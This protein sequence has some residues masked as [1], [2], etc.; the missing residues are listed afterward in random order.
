MSMFAGGC[1]FR[2]AFITKSLN[3]GKTMQQGDSEA[4]KVVSDP[5]FDRVDRVAA[6]LGLRS[7]SQ[8]RP[9]TFK[10]LRSFT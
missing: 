7:A 1:E 10:L 5:D 3:G 8:P 2:V 9:N 6:L 4:Y